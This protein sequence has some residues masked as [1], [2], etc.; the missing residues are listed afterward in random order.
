MAIASNTGWRTGRNSPRRSF[1][2]ALP[3]CRRSWP[4]ALVAAQ[5]SSPAAIPP[6]AMSARS[7]P[8]AKPVAVSAYATLPSSTRAVRMRCAFCDWLDSLSKDGRVSQADAQSRLRPGMKRIHWL[9]NRRDSNVS[10]GEACARAACCAAKMLASKLAP[11]DMIVKKSAIIKPLFCLRILGV[12]FDT[13]TLN[14][15]APIGHAQTLVLLT[16]C[17]CVI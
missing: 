1:R 11:A 2:T 16:Y 13:P 12:S 14:R 3:S 5:R 7:S 8:R 15:V 6:A 4:L 9:R 17:G 10:S